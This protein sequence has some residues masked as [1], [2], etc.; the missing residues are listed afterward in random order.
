MFNLNFIFSPG[1]C[2]YFCLKYITHTKIKK[3]AYMNLWEM[4]EYLTQYNYYCTCLKLSNLSDVTR[5]CL[6]LIE[7]KNGGKHYV[8][9]KYISKNRVVY[10]DPLFLF[11]RKKK[12]SNFS[13]IWS[14]ICLFYTKV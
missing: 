3:E 13:K 1:S 9:I 14:G 7:N 10:Y 6:T 12:T 11:V 4:K 8:V 5:E 2:G